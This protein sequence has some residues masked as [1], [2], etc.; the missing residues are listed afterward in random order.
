MTQKQQIENHR[1]LSEK[2]IVVLGGSSGIVEIEL[3]PDRGTAGDLEAPAVGD[4][5]DQQ[6]P[7]TR[8]AVGTLLRRQCRRARPPFCRP[9][10]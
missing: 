2:R 8:R 4:R 9:K 3:E 10:A 7:A 1:E 6:E 5:R